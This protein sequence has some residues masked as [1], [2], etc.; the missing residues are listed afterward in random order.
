MLPGFAYGSVAQS[1]MDNLADP[2]HLSKCAV[3][4]EL[5]NLANALC[6]AKLGRYQ[7]IME[8]V[9]SVVLLAEAL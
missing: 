4:G 3:D 2:S 8:R 5:R 7:D 6:F 1:S 9:V